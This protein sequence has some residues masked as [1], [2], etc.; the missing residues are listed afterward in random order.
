MTISINLLR[1]GFSSLRIAACSLIFVYHLL[2]LYGVKIYWLSTLAIS[3]FIFLSGFFSFHPNKLSLQWLSRRLQAILL[4]Y[5]VVMILVV[6]A[7]GF[8]GYKHFSFPQYLVMFL[9]GSLFID[10]PLYVISWYV[11]FIL[12]FYIFIFAFARLKYWKW[13]SFVGFYLFYIT[14]MDKNRVFFFLFFG[15]YYLAYALQ[16]KVFSQYTESA[17]ENDQILNWLAR[18]TYPFFLINGGVL[19]FFVKIMP[20]SLYLNCIFSFFL[21]VAFSILMTKFVGLVRYLCKDADVKN[22][23]AV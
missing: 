21:T 12:I 9:G 6:I 7:N 22:E 17:L 11:T 16:E 13:I 15:G 2:S 3:I 20:L 23:I 18:L 14:C 8:V 10:D 4:P 5:W 1:N 19:L